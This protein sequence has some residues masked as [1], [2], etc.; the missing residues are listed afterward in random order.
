MEGRLKV[1][2][3]RRYFVLEKV[4]SRSFPESI[5]RTEKHRPPA[6]S[7]VLCVCLDVFCCYI[8]RDETSTSLAI[9]TVLTQC[10]C[11]IHASQPNRSLHYNCCTCCQKLAR[12]FIV[13]EARKGKKEE[14]DYK[15]I[16]SLLLH[17]L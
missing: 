12:T 7:C 11:V 1:F 2:T 6:P 5:K 15:R 10:R 17:E 4:F 13:E 3:G 9:G 16:P 14:Q 8:M